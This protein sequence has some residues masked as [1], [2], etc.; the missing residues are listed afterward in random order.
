MQKAHKLPHSMGRLLHAESGPAGAPK[1]PRSDG[2]VGAPGLGQFADAYGG[3]EFAQAVAFLDGVLQ[4]EV[5]HG[6][7]VGAIQAEN[8][9][10]L[11][12]PTANSLHLHKILDDLI[13]GQA[14][15]AAEFELAAAG[16]ACEVTEITDFLPGEADAAKLAKGRTEKFGGTRETTAARGV[17]LLK[18]ARDGARGLEG[19]LLMDDGFGECAELVAAL[20]EMQAQRTDAG[21]EAAEDRVRALQM[22][23]SRGGVFHGERR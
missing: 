4:A 21:D 19:Q 3:R 17:E 2:A 23:K 13:I 11:R 1:I 15:E 22:S 14:A 20:L 7:N 5:V 10:H 18:T 6:K 9:K 16:A 12:G 8:Q